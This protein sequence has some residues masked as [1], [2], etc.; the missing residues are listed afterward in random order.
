M[1]SANINERSLS[2][3]RDSE[4]ALLCSPTS[5]QQLLDFR[6]ALLADHAGEDAAFWGTPPGRDA[7]RTGREIAQE[8]RARAAANWDA[9]SDNAAVRA[10]PHRHIVPYPIVVDPETGAV[11]WGGIPDCVLPVFESSTVPQLLVE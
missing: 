9:Y 8:L 7:P 2:G 5:A 1:G 6:S 11:T 4:V 10:L 3:E